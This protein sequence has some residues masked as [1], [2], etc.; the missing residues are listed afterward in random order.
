M[1][2]EA[3]PHGSQVTQV[4]PRRKRGTTSCQVPPPCLRD[5]GSG[6]GWQLGPRAHR[7]QPPAVQTLLWAFP[8]PACLWPS[9]ERG[10]GPARWEQPSP[11]LHSPNP[12]LSLCPGLDASPPAST[13]ELTIPNDVSTSSLTHLSPRAPLPG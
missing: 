4:V 2:Q 8:S 7:P 11:S 1:S 9:G 10:Q 12:V 13:H 3:V 6:E 5:A